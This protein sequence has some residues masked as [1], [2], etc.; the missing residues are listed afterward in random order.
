MQKHVSENYQTFIKKWSHTLSEE[1][2]ALFDHAA[3]FFEDAEALLLTKPCTLLHGELKFPN[4]FWDFGTNGGEPIFIDWQYVGPGQGIEDVIFLL[5]E[6]C[7]V[8]NFKL[9]AEC[10]IQ[11]YYDEREKL[12]DIEIS[13][14]TQRVQVSCALAGSP[15]FVAVW[16]GCIDA[17]KLSEPNFPFLYITRLA[18]AFAQ[19]YDKDWTRYRL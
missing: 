14:S 5:V 10:L 8:S 19:L 3:L 2:V 11:S 12:D 15:F 6:S 9:L 7:G 13:Q 16:F 17:S 1:V 4:L 18:N